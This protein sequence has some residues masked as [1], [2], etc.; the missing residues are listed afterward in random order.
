MVLL[1]LSYIIYYTII[2]LRLMT[3]IGFLVSLTTFV[4]GVIYIYRRLFMEV[5]LGF[6]SIIVAIF[7]STSIILFSLG[8]IGEYISRIYVKDATKPP[9]VIKE[10]R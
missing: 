1:T 6:T 5:E 8:I 9:F 3:Y 4:I 7:F 10:I 2:P